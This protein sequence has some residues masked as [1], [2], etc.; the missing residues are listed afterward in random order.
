MKQTLL[1]LAAAAALAPGAEIVSHPRLLKFEPL[2]YQPP[3]PA[4]YR[5]VLSNGAVAYLVEDHVF[6]L[7]NLAVTIRTGQYLDPPDKIGLASLTGE[8]IRSGGTEKRPP[9]EFDEEADF[10][11]ANMTSAIGDTQGTASLNCLSRNLDAALGLF[12]EMLRS[13]GFDPQQISLAKA[14][15]LQAMTRRNDQTQGIE[16]R[17]W[18]RLLYGP[19]HFSTAQDTKASIDAITRDDLVAFHRRYYHAANFVLAVSGDFDTRAMLAKLE[20][21]IRGWGGSKPD[22]AAVPKPDYKPRPGVYVVHKPGVNQCRVSVGHLGITR[23]NPDQFAVS[24]MNSILGGGAFTSRIMSRVRS[25]EGLAYSAGSMMTPGVYYPGAFRAFFQS[26]SATCAQAA[27]IVLEEIRRI[28]TEKVSAEELSTAI[29]Y[30]V[31]VFPRFFATPAIV[32][33]TFAADEYT[34][35]PAGYWD[36]YRQKLR[37]VTADDVLRAAQ[38]Y[39]NP[40]GLVIL[41]VGNAEDVLKGDP[42]KPQYS[43]QKLGTIRRIPLPDPLTMTYPAE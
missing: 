15:R 2:N 43:F 6:P 11:A 24:V 23:D 35:R 41:A 32:A 18:E 14:R 37:E 33:A 34:H 27:D 3:Q 13:P 36:T 22:I 12:F 21:A 30:A 29:N 4:R 42:T 19:N 20:E 28:R 1:L 10:L 31:E 38:K 9:R 26:K 16:Q 7:V 25:D 40:E 17:E 5:H 8:L 39:L